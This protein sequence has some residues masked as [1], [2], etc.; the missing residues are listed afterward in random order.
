MSGADTK[1]APTKKKP[2]KA[3]AFFICLVIASFLWLVHALNAVYTRNFKVPVSYRNIPQNKQPLSPLPEILSVDV[4]ASGLKLAL[5][6]LKKPFASLDLDFN[7][8]KAAGRGQ[9]YVLSAQQLNFKSIFGFEGQV[10]HISP[11]TLYFSEKTGFQKTVTIKVPI[12]V[13]CRQG[14]TARQPLVSPAF[15]TI[16]GD[17]ALIRNIDTIYTQALHLND[18]YQN[19]NT[20][21]ALVKPGNGVYPGLSE[22]SVSI[23]VDR[24]MEHSTRVHVSDILNHKGGGNVS[25][26]PSHVTVRF[27]S[28]GNNFRNEDTALFKASINSAKINR[29]TKKYPVFLNMVPGHVNVL[30]IEPREVEVLI[31]KH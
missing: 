25:I 7:Q 4:K 1:Y 19:V 23:E 8:I 26:F 21:V 16:F 24:L 14:Y 29:A 15:T 22:A 13:K 12:Y 9:N 18:L 11:D 6:Q 3:K 30:E 10:K 31:L 2:G 5:I 28:A 27:T 17:T 20:R